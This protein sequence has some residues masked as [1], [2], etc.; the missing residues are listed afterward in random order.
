MKGNLAV[1]TAP[2]VNMSTVDMC[3][4]AVQTAP[5]VNMSTVDM[6]QLAVQT[7]RKVTTRH[8]QPLTP[9]HFK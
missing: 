1:Q 8:S 2:K 4:L 3:K 7:A 9:G 6:C 5:K